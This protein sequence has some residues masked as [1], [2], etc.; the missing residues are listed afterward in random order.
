MP[1]EMAKKIKP[2]ARPQ[3]ETMQAA[4]MVRGKQCAT[5][6]LALIMFEQQDYPGAIEYLERFI[7]KDDPRSR[8]TTPARYL[9]AR[10]YEAQGDRDRAIELYES[11]LK[12]PQADGNRLRARWLKA[13][14]AAADQSASSPTADETKP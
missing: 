6:W 8:W 14:V 1:D 2:E 5:Y 11:D 12:S 4:T 13:E 7:L 3:L 9:L 10:C